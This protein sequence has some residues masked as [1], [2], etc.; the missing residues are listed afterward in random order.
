M[1]QTLVEY[2]YDVIIFSGSILEHLER[3]EVVFSK[4]AE[5]G[6]KLKPKKCHFIQREVV[7]LGH[8]FSQAGISTDPSSWV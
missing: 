4:L 2:L 8:I 1:W 6:L 3:L 7:N 5:V